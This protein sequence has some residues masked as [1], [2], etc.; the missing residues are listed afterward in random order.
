MDLNGHEAGNGGYSQGKSKVHRVSSTRREKIIDLVGV[1]TDGT[2]IYASP[3]QAVA[4]QLGRGIGWLLT[5]HPRQTL[6]GVALA[7]VG[8]CICYLAHD[9]VKRDST[10][11]KYSSR[12][13]SEH[14]KRRVRRFGIYRR[15][16][17]RASATR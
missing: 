5:E 15:A 4:M 9:A 6:G 16:P 8:A 10:T 12:G 14:P 11:R 1:E 3:W 2:V 13:A 7:S 17:A